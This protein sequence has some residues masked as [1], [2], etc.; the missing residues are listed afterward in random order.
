M[1]AREVVV[2]DIGDFADVPVIEILVKPGDRIA[3]DDPLITLESDKATMDIPSPYDGVVDEL[4]VAVGDTVSEG[5]PIV[6]LGEA[7]ASTDGGPPP[8]APEVAS[9]PAA[10][11]TPPVEEKPAARPSAGTEDLVHAGPAVRAYAREREV[12]LTQVTGTGQKGRI[13]KDD[14]EAYLAGAAPA[15]V[16]AAAA[17]AGAGLT[18]LAWPQVDFSKFGPTRS[19]PLSR[20]KKISGPSLHRNWVMIPHVTH[21]DE[22]DITELEGFRKQNAEASKAQ[23]IRLT[24]LAFLVKASVAALAR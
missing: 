5:S 19:E 23:G 1:A 16:G 18:V 9:A 24:M 14:V 3:I 22:A 6:L 10:E 20:I 12:D 17:P 21:N 13:R 7:G 15:R 8:P 11:S 2:P 4:K